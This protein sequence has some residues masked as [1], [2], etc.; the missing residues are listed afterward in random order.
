MSKVQ[1]DYLGI[2]QDGPY[3]VR[4]SM[5]SLALSRLVSLF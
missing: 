2:P 1:A 4:L 5:S 3:K